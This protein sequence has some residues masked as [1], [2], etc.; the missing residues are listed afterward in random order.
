LNL[1]LDNIVIGRGLAALKS[2]LRCQ[3]YLFYQLKN[4]FFKE[5][6]IGGGAIFASVTKKDLLNQKILT[7]SANLIE[8][9]ENFSI[10]VDEQIKILFLQNQKLKQARDLLLPKLMNGEIVV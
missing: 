9:F 2:K 7:A 5:D 6:I 3:S 10:P 8:M 4:H 1:T